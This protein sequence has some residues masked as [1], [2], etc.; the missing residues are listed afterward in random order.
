MHKPSISEKGRL[1]IEIVKSTCIL[2]RPQDQ[3]PPSKVHISYFLQK[4]KKG[5]AQKWDLPFWYP[6]TQCFW[7]YVDLCSIAVIAT[8]T[9]L[10][11]RWSITCFTP[12]GITPIYCIIIVIQIRKACNF[13]NNPFFL[14]HR[15]DWTII[16]VVFRFGILGLNF[17]RSLKV[18]IGISW[19]FISCCKIIDERQASWI[20][21][22]Q[23]G[24]QDRG[25][26]N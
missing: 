21:D 13:N 24:T 22:L 10:D 19:N 20:F 26:C 25:V 4:C 6:K 3:K 9:R 7:N 15:S 18:M 23:A 16:A 8:S 11:R 14:I 5:K 1:I 12:D 2:P 17:L